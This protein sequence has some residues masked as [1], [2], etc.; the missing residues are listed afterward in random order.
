MLG[1]KVS[2][3]WK[4]TFKLLEKLE[5][6]EFENSLETIG[7]NGV[8][9]LKRATPKDSGL[10]ANSWDYT[11]IHGDSPAIEWHNYDIEGGC[12]VVILIEYGHGLHQGGYIAPRPFVDSALRPVFDSAVEEIWREVNKL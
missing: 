9:S 8:E 12:N 1:L 6:F 7:K 3:D 4:K 5:D 11:I 2:G 10:A